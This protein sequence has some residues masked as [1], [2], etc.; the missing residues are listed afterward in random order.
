[1]AAEARQLEPVRLVWQDGG[2][3][4]V[5]EA[6]DE[7]RF[8]MTCQQ[9]AEACARG[10]RQIEWQSQFEKILTLVHAW[11]TKA[12]GRVRACFV[13]PREGQLA[14]FAVPA[15]DAFDPD[16]AD[17]ISDLD[18]EIAKRFELC[19]CE[20]LQIPGQTPEALA[21]FLNPS[22]ALQIYGE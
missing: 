6:K 21:T 18:M 11:A 5:V 1:M 2:R 16:L 14:I 15:S 7:D 19:Q 4:V 13:S 9:A 3:M 20:V 10:N 22:E 17:M 12:K 8:V